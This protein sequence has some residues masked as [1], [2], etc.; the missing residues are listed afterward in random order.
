MNAEM[1][2]PNGEFLTK[3][4]VAV[5]LCASLRSV[6][7]LMQQRKLPYYRISRRMIRFRRADVLNY[8][9]ANYRINARGE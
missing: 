4:D 2:V 1:S 9:A 3:R 5:L 7:S 6:D 8:L